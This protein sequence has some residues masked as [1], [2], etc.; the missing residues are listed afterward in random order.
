MGILQ[1]MKAYIVGERPELL[2]YLYMIQ[3]R[4]LKPLW[5]WDHDKFISG[6][7][8]CYER[9][10]GYSF[11]IN[12]PITFN[13]KLQWY[14]IFY[15]RDDFAQ[16][17]DKVLFKNYVKENFGD[18]SLKT[19]KMYG[20]WEDIESMQRDWDKLPQR[21]VLK[22]N[23]MANSMGVMII[24][25]KNAIDFK[26][27]RRKL[28]HWLNPLVTLRNS[29]DW[30]FY[31]SSPKILAE[32]FLQDQYGE[33]RD[34]KFFCF[35]G[36]V[37]CFRVDYGRAEQHHATFFDSNY[38]ELDISV[39]GF[40]KDENVNIDLPD[41]IKEMYAW[42]EKLSKG[43]PFIRVDFF[44]CHGEFYLSELTFAPGGGV[45]HYPKEYDIEWGKYFT[46]PNN[47]KGKCSL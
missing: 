32:E 34:Y 24:K 13:E 36:Y 39:P 8:S 46:L 19:V 41:N 3:R 2:P 27:L 10:M 6:V 42:A 23:L 44:S 7:M 22:S 17:T 35:D 4:S 33:L 16:I 43:F 29:W 28:K 9:H 5:E 15:H 25:D 40:T 47:S 31:N 14:K 37:P 38:N 30:H 20:Y 1:K 11:D 21:F 18:G 12:N 45:T 26:K